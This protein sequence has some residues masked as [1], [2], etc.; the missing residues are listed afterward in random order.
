MRALWASLCALA[1]LAA[2]LVLAAV[3]DMASE[4]MR[5][6]LRQLPEAIILLAAWLVPEEWRE[7]LGDE[8]R[9]ELA[10]ILDRT[11]DVPVTGLTMGIWYAVGL[12]VR[13]RAVARGLSGTT[14][15]F[16]DARLLRHLAH[17]WR[18]V[19]GI[20]GRLADRGASGQVMIRGKPVGAAAIGIY[21]VLT[22]TLAITIAAAGLYVLQ[23][24]AG[25]SAVLDNRVIALPAAPPAAP[26]TC[27]EATQSGFRSPATS[28]CMVH[29]SE[30]TADTAWI[31]Q[32]RGFAPGKPVTVSLTWNSPLQL[33][34]NATVRRTAPVKPVTG[35]D[36][37][38][39]LNISK[40]F[41]RSLQLGEFIVKVTGS[42]GSHATT[43]FIVLP[44]G[45]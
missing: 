32:G 9:S 43:V 18:E 31:V 39:H 36:G 3:S 42:G 8:W 20:P 13:G 38:L 19:Q 26:A 15:R 28:L 10:A 30:G 37:T 2:G 7:E 16:G 25:P 4:E 24:P 11:K 1:A 29:Q 14:R 41:P 6:R 35:Q 23:S 27:G 45:P 5:T 34:P 12:L 44:Q 17:L 22:L 21:P 40:L 33:A